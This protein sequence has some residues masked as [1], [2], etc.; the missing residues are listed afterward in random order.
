MKWDQKQT[1]ETISPDDVSARL[2]SKLETWQEELLEGDAIVHVLLRKSPTGAEVKN[3]TSRFLKWGRLDEV[4]SAT[5]NEIAQELHAAA[6]HVRGAT[7]CENTFEVQARVRIKG[8]LSW[9][10]ACFALDDR[11]VADGEDAPEPAAKAPGGLYAEAIASMMVGDGLVPVAAV[12]L[13]GLA[14][15]QSE[16]RAARQEARFDRLLDMTLRSHGAADTVLRMLDPLMNGSGRILELGV[17][18]STAFMDREANARQYMAEIEF[19][20]HRADKVG[21]GVNEALK[22]GKDLI[23]S[24]LGANGFMGGGGASS[25]ST[26]MPSA[27]ASRVEIAAAVAGRVAPAQVEALRRIDS[28]AADV[29]AR[30]G[31]NCTDADVEQFTSAFHSVMVTNSSAISKWMRGLSPE[32]RTLLDRLVGS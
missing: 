4:E 10:S 23:S 31:A 16:Q 13:L 26:P 19:R 15:D 28:G 1:W 20:K 32:A 27:A 9:R 2:V 29:L 30:F 11:T 21:D 25:S 22:L 8:E 17:N 5:A 18:L 24:V 3:T 7:G 12:G 6:L 14:L